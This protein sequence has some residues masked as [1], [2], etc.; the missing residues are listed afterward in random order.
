MG[1]CAACPQGL[2]VFSFSWGGFPGGSGPGGSGGTIYDTSPSSF[3]LRIKEMRKRMITNTLQDWIDEN[4]ID[5]SVED[6]QDLIDTEESCVTIFTVP[7]SDGYD[8]P[9]NDPPPFVDGD[10]IAEELINTGMIFNEPVNPCEKALVRQYPIAAFK[11]FYNSTIA[12]EKTMEVFGVS[13]R[14]DCSDA[15]RHCF[16]N[17]L[18]T[19]DVGVSLA[20]QFSD[21]HECNQSDN[22]SLMDIHNN[23]KG[24]LIGDLWPN[25]NLTVLIDQTCIRLESGDLRVL[26]DQTDPNSNLISSAI[27]GCQC[28]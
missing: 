4:G 15:F 19:Q 11:V 14:L 20:K 17:A 24:Q 16:F 12:V 10:C 28:L 13:G 1:S 22:E 3:G 6:L 21:A 2:G 26:E 5:I 9:V 8:V 23:G 27:S 18:N 25:A 7:N